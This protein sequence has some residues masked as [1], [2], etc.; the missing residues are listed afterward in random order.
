[1][2]LRVITCGTYLGLLCHVRSSEANF[3]RLKS[4]V[5]SACRVYWCTAAGVARSV[6]RDVDRE[7]G[8]TEIKSA[9]D[10]DQLIVSGV[11]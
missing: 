11:N 5:V 10:P 8:R 1:M 4:A 7:L 6:Q 9:E 3:E 2:V